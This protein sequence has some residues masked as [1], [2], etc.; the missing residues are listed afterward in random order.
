MAVLAVAVVSCGVYC[1]CVYAWPAIRQHPYFRLRSVKITCDSAYVEPAVLASR[2]GLY[3]GTSLWDVD[4]DSARAALEAA[5]WV[6]EARVERRFPDHVSVE[7]YRR[8]PIAATLAS[9][10]PYLIGQDGVVYR[11]EKRQRYSDL[12]DVP[13]LTGWERATSHGESVVRLRAAIALLRAAKSA[14]IVVSQ[15]DVGED[16]TLWLFPEA[17]QVA[18]RFGREAHRAREMARLRTVLATLPR[19]TDDLEEIDLTYA[20]RA[21]VR[22]RDGRVNSVL[23]EIASSDAVTGLAGTRTAGLGAEGDRG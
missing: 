13:Y 3:D 11:E 16:G 19:E 23:S 22:V 6:R 9:D 15:V 10:G 5:P 20:D 21:V 1:T 7:V 17:P 18:V 14:G 12:P 4:V 2:A 8:E